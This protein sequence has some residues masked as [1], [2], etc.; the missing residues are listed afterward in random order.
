MKATVMFKSQNPSL[1]DFK[2][3]FQVRHLSM[4]SVQTSC[5]RHNKVF[6]N[7]WEEQKAAVTTFAI[8]LQLGFSSLLWLC[9]VPIHVALFGPHSRGQSCQRCMLLQKRLLDCS[10]ASDTTTLSPHTKMLAWGMGWGGGDQQ[11]LHLP[12]T[13]NPTF[14]PSSAVISQVCGGEKVN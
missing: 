8:S 3:C 1:F 12:E 4:H 6:S 13:I 7:Q 14:T 10:V 5:P 9:T 11:F 2:L